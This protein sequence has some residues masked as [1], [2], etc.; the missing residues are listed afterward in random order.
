V[1]ELSR[2][3]EKEGRGVRGDELIV[4]TEPELDM[5]RVRISPLGGGRV[6]RGL[7]GLLGG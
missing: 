7:E 6:R 3:E 5:V 2:F 1:K 4:E